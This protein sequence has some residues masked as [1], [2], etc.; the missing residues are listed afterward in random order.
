MANDRLNLLV[1]RRRAGQLAAEQLS[2]FKQATLALV[3]LQ[4]KC[5]LLVS[6][7]DLNIGPVQKR[8]AR[9]VIILE[10]VS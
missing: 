4:D 10:Y 2:H 6:T 7:Q 1:F 5:P 8:R 3:E 9:Q